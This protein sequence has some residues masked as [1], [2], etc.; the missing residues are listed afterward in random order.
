[1]KERLILKYVLRRCDFVFAGTKDMADRVR[2][3]GYKG[4]LAIFR[5]GVDP[6]MFRRI[7]PRSA[8]GFSILS[9][10]PCSR[11]YNPLV[12]VEAF[13]LGL[14]Q[15]GSANLWM[16]DFGNMV[17]DVHRTVE[18]DPLLKERVKFIPRKSFDEM[19]DVYNSA[20]IAVS[21]PDSD[22]AAASVL[23]A[24]ACEVPVIASDI[25]PM[26]EWVD[27]GAT[28]Y[29]TQ[30]DP[31]RLADKMR[32]AYSMRA[33]LGPM[34]RRAREKVLDEKNQGTFESNIRVAEESYRKL[35]G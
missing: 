23:E 18:S 26:R 31:S 6:A 9:I 35:L 13:K 2:A 32:K 19:V 11:I 4:E 16:L 22:S 8:S 3:N 34:G 29:L 28:G 15:L 27:E 14:P 12:I 10:R 30:I 1:M 20:D 7:S 33:M 21:I 24:M 5:F 17:D 25:P